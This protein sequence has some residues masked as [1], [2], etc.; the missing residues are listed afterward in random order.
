MARRPATLPPGLDA[1]ALAARLVQVP[2]I[3]AVTLGGSRARGEHTPES[4]VDLG[5]YYRPP[6]DT[7]A[8]G[9]LARAVAGPD[10]AVTLP[11]EW[12][13]WVDG[14]ACPGP[15]AGGTGGRGGGGRRP[16]PGRGRGLRG[17]G[18]SPVTP[19]PR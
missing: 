5:L 18:L 3:V 6:L 17:S 4:D 8:L 9:D 15:P 10:A 19:R 14:G 11:G 16:G 7:G 1:A 12:G 2:G 13:P